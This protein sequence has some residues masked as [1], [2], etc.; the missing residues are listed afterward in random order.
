MKLTLF[1]DTSL[2][3]AS[4]ALLLENGENTQL[5]EDHSLQKGSTDTQLCRMLDKALEKL[6]LHYENI[7]GIVLSHGPGS[8]TGIKVGLA[9]AYGFQASHKEPLL[10]GMSS[11][12][13]ATSRLGEE[14]GKKVVTILPISRREAFVCSRNET[15][16]SFST[17]FL[18]ANSGEEV[19]RK[20]IEKNYSMIL[21]SEDPTLLEWVRTL[22]PF[23]ELCS[24]EK[25]SKTALKAL[26]ETYKKN[27]NITK[28]RSIP[29]QYF[30]RTTVE[31][32][33]LR[34]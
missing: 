18:K 8:F 16:D 5:I 3:G 32:N 34:G 29:A 9:W 31:E 10:I 21:I 7:H 15:E 28:K 20:F 22:T 1:I 17:I 4:V 30:K 26:I 12:A 14:K 33:F 6:S 27:P 11:L 25:F 19:L 13:E 24:M 23:S 2:Q